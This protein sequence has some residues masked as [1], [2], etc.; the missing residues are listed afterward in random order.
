MGSSASKKA[1]LVHNVVLATKA[2]ENGRKISIVEVNGLNILIVSHRSDLATAEEI[3]M[4]LLP[5]KCEYLDENG[6]LRFR[7]EMVNWAQIIILAVSNLFQRE[8]FLEEL[9]CYAQILKKKL[10]TVILENHFE[11][12]G[13]VGL[14]TKAYGQFAY[15]KDGGELACKFL[16]DCVERFEGK[17]DSNQPIVPLP[18]TKPAEVCFSF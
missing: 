18:E 16:S 7:A 5:R 2:F 3:R 9:V 14:L 11:P 13:C 17:V 1:K 10:I 8:V 6:S 4:F 15:W 12:S